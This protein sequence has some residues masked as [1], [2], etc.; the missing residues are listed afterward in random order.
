VKKLI[1][2]KAIALFG[3]TFNP[4]HKGHQII[5]QSLQIIPFIKKVLV[6]PNHIPPHKAFEEIEGLDRIQALEM[7]I[8]ALNRA[9]RNIE[10]ELSTVEIDRKGLSWTIDTLKHLEAEYPNCTIYYVIGSDSYFSFHTW[11][12]Y[13]EILK[14]V[15]L[16]IVNREKIANSTKCRNYY[17]KHL[18]SVPWDNFIFFNNK[19]IEISSTQIRQDIKASSVGQKDNNLVIG[20]T[21]RVGSGKTFA[22]KIIQDSFKNT[23]IIDLDKIGHKLLEEPS[24]KR[25]LIA[26]FS[27]DILTKSE[28]TSRKK[29][30]DLAFANKENL[31][32]LNKIM[33]PAIKDIVIEKIEKFSNK[34]IVIVGALIEEIGLKSIC[35]K[36]IVVVA[37]KT[38]IKPL[39]NQKIKIAKIQRSDSFYIKNADIVID[40]DFTAAFKTKIIGNLK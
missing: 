15:K 11:K 12:N 27:K 16:I 13:L 3:G 38:K 2:L 21:G 23:K 22:A 5:L 8:N 34:K 39:S 17:E 30:G 31:S 32:A 10:Y 14:K 28:K 37:E 6:I 1:N 19:P 40:N 7:E 9:S 25:K 4:F 29:L 35:D 26:K 33:H 18:S 36:T 24:I 20:L